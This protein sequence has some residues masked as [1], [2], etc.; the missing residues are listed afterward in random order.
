MIEAFRTEIIEA[1]KSRM[2]LIK[3]KPILV[4][5]LGSVGLGI[6]NSSQK[7]QPILSLHLLLCLIPFVCVYVDLLC[8]HIQIRILNISEFFQAYDAYD[9]KVYHNKND[10]KQ[11]S[12]IEQ[13]EEMKRKIF[14][15]QEYERYCD[16]NRNYNIFSLEDWVLRWSTIFLSTLLALTGLFSGIQGFEKVAFL[17]SGIFGICLTAL[18]DIIMDFNKRKIKNIKDINSNTLTDIL[19]KNTLISIMF[20]IKKKLTNI[21]NIK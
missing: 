18:I 4:A 15:I 20:D 7:P 11:S 1:T 19:F 14:L 6:G 12:K 13:S 2:E 9:F 16:R 8:N 3:L 17:V 10:N 5:A 21:K